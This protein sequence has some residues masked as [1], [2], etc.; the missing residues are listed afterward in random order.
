[1]WPSFELYCN[2]GEKSVRECCKVFEDDRGNIRLSQ[3]H[4]GFMY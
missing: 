4:S 1:M 2:I 3:N